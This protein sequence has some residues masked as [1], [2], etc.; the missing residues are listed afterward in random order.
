[1]IIEAWAQLSQTDL[2][3]LWAQAKDNPAP[4]IELIALA[5]GVR[6]FWRDISPNEVVNIIGSFDEIKAFYDTYQ[7]QIISLDCWYQGRG[8]DVIEVGLPIT[9]PDR[10][11]S[12]MPDFVTIDEDGTPIEVIPPTKQ[13]PNWSHMFL[14]QE[15]ASKIF[16][17]DYALEFSE[18]FL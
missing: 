8:L 3:S 17:G 5:N 13:A 9:D 18:E 11:L 6:G 1:M 16:A 2:N 14:G 7:S 10:I 15:V 4:P 12:F